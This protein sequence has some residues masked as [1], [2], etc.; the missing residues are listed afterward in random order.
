[1]IRHCLGHH[2]A[3]WPGPG[4]PLRPIPPECAS[5]ARERLR[6]L[7]RNSRQRREERDQAGRSPGTSGR[8]GPRAPVPGGGIRPEQPGAADVPAPPAGRC[9]WL[10][11]SVSPPE[12]ASNSDENGD[13]GGFEFP[14]LNRPLTNGKLWAL[15]IDPGPWSTPRRRRHSPASHRGPT[16]TA[17]GLDTGHTAVSFDD[18]RVPAEPSLQ[19]G[20]ETVVTG[21]P[22][23]QYRAP[24]PPMA[25]PEMGYPVP[26]DDERRVEPTFSGLA[27]VVAEVPKPDEQAAHRDVVDAGTCT[28]GDFLPRLPGPADA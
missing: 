7:Q 6:R 16:P 17:V 24:T 19:Q 9:C 18:D 12:T 3:D 23:Q 21:S 8:S 15:G 22:R 4:Q 20:T 5:E 13:D 1:M 27:A 10:R 14:E 25:S 26:P 28:Q 2:H 11:R